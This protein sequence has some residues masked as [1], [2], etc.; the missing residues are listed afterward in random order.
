VSFGQSSSALLRGH[1]Q[2]HSSWSQRAE[3]LH[4]TTLLGI[5]GALSR[6]TSGTP[7]ASRRT[8]RRARRTVIGAIIVL[9]V[10]GLFAKR[11][12]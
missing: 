6:P 1:R 12:A 9:V 5:A 2:V 4:L 3:R 7:L 11:T 8:K 10:W